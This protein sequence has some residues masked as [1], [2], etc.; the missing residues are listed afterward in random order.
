MF[1]PR[2]LID[3]P[4]GTI[5]RWRVQA[6]ARIADF[7]HMERPGDE[8]AHFQAGGGDTIGDAARR[9]LLVARGEPK[10]AALERALAAE[11]DPMTPASFLNRSADATFLTDLPGVG[12]GPRPD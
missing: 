7:R 2:A 5:G 3:D 12:R 10:R 9:V 1:P 6:Q 8:S 11:G 4:R